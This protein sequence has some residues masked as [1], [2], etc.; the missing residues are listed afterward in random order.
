[1]TGAA[2]LVVEVIAVRM[3]SPYYGSSLYVLSSVLTI[4]L[5]ALSAGYFIG[6]RLSDRFPSS[7]LLF[8]IIAISGLTVIG[9]DVLGTHVLPL[10]SILFPT[11]VG[12]LVLGI[13]LFFVPAFLLGVVSPFV[14]KLQSIYASQEEI[15]SVVG[16]TFFWGTFGSI[17]GSLITGFVLIPFLGLHSSLVG[18]GG[19]IVFLG[20]GGGI[21]FARLSNCDS[22]MSLCVHLVRKRYYLLKIFLIFLALVAISKVDPFALIDHVLYEKDSQYSK[23]LVYEATL[24]QEHARIL[25]NDTNASSATSLDSY[26]LLFG[27]T[28]FAELYRVLK[29]DTTRFLLLG[30]GA[31]SIPRTLVARDPGI[32]IDVIEIEPQLFVIAQEYF[33]LD[34]ISRIHNFIT[35]ARVY[36]RG[37]NTQYDVIFGDAFGSDHNIPTHLATREFFIEAKK[38]L[39]ENGIFILNS[40]GVLHGEAPTLIGSLAKT[41]HEVFPNVKMYALEGSTFGQRQ[42]IVFVARNGIEPIEL[43]GQTITSIHGEKRALQDIEVSFATFATQHELVFVDDVAPIEYL[44]FRQL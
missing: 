8:E 22:S 5:G 36:F 7:K 20:L 26:N 28:Q 12:P 6:G 25:K 19:M 33:L 18:T 39:K 9:I 34:D 24:N 13:F 41:L 3:L 38:D 10:G 23:I 31:Y 14:I 35:D 40:I 2:V 30:G 4:I 32:T 37:N 43:T 17:A 44:M 11:M 29:P 42:N 1:M 15:G 16:A 27:Y 21:A